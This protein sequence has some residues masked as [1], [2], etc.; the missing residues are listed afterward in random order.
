[1]PRL[2]WP[3]IQH[4]INSGNDDVSAHFER[5]L[6]T[7]LACSPSHVA[8]LAGR[9]ARNV[10]WVHGVVNGSESLSKFLDEAKSL[11][12]A[13]LLSGLHAKVNLRLKSAPVLLDSTDKDA[14]MAVKPASIRQSSTDG[15]PS[16]I[17]K[18][19]ITSGGRE[20][21]NKNLHHTSFEPGHE[22]LEP[23]VSL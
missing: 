8:S 21:A 13:V 12:F 11:G 22:K 10:T 18:R 4:T 20:M 9:L 3:S 23:P 16:D 2:S 19:E 17:D 14:K 7:K 1:M 5:V 6:G 15:R